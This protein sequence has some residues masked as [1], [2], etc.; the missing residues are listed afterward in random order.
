MKI[1]RVIVIII[2]FFLLTGCGETN[3][4]L[5]FSQPANGSRGQTWRYEINPEGVLKEIDFYDS[6]I[7]PTAHYEN[8]VFEP[9]NR[10]EVTINWVC[11]V[12][13]TSVEEDECYSV[14][15]L[16][17]ENLKVKKIFDSRD[18]DNSVPSLQPVK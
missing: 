12:M 4:K 14:T 9:I 10:G 18:T 13:G 2:L 7:F 11:S 15:Y 3:N 8:W 6:Y 1:I 16:V 17:D 5:H